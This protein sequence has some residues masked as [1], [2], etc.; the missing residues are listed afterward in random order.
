[1]KQFPIAKIDSRFSIRKLINKIKKECAVEQ[2]ITLNPKRTRSTHSIPAEQYQIYVNLEHI[3]SADSVG[4][5]R[6]T[7]PN[8]WRGLT[9]EEAL[10]CYLQEL[11]GFNH[12]KGWHYLLLGTGEP[13]DFYGW[14]GAPMLQHFPQPQLHWGIKTSSIFIGWAY[15]TS[16][17]EIGEL[18]IPL[19][20]ETK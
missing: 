18:I 9:L 16:K 12:Q 7:Y 14:M 17:F 5:M 15:L 11:D 19:A 1:M 2:L 10:H 3:I 8:D 13:H 4:A 6:E 20:K